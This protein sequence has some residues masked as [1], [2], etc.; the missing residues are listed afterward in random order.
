MFH[1]SQGREKAVCERC[2]AP[3]IVVWLVSHSEGRGQ[4]VLGTETCWGGGDMVE[5]A[6]LRLF[7]LFEL[8][9]TVTL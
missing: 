1:S 9:A 2:S 4:C 6:R 8:E 7:D 3:G 5:A